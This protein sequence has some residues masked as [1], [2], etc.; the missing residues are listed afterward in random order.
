MLKEIGFL[1]AGALVLL[2]VGYLTYSEEAEKEE[3]LLLKK[4][5]QEQRI[6]AGL[7]PNPPKGYC[8]KHHESVSFVVPKKWKRDASVVLEQSHN[9]RKGI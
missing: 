4:K 9:S 5:K 7:P 6:K 2:G 1:A 3:K 8:W